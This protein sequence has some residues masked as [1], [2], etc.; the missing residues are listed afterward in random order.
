LGLEA[1]KAAVEEYARRNGATVKGT[2]VE[3]ETGKIADRPE[4]M[5]AMAHARRGKATLVVAKL[6]RLARN[7][8]FLLSVVEGTTDVVFCDLPSIPPGPT[9]KFILTQMAA[10]AELEAGLIAQRTRDAMAVAKAKGQLFGSARPG[11]WEG[12]EDVRLAAL[13]KAREKA[14][15]VRRQNAEDAYADLLPDL[16]AMRAEGLTLAEIATRL[17]ESGHTTRRG[18]AWNAMQVHRVLA[19]AAG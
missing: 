17:T 7:A 11:H 15:E 2:Y 14:V 18:K 10:V 13:E 5:K 3:V 12:R 19:R 4:L 16:L 6:D 9:G 8:R 1:Q